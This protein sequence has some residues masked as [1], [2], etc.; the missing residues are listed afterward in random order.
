M[1]DELPIIRAFYELTVWLTPKIVRFPRDDKF[2][3]GEPANTA[4]DPVAD[5]CTVR[6]NSRT[7]VNSG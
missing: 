1:H 7:R 6:L 3:L 2:V 4:P 5:R